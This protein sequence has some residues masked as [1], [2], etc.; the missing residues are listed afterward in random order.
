[1]KGMIDLDGLLQNLFPI[2]KD[3]HL[4]SIFLHMFLFSGK[5]IIPDVEIITT[6]R[7]IKGLWDFS[8]SCPY[9]D[10]IY[11]LAF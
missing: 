7:N 1:M 5:V 9:E 6:H 10:P 8:I 2:F 4:A 11:S 3:R